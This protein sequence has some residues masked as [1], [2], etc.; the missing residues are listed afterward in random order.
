[1]GLKGDRVILETDI[2]YSCA[3]VASRGVTL[4]GKT[5]GSGVALGD[6]AGVADLV[7][8]PSGKKVLGI[9][10]NDVVNIDETRYHRNFHKDETKI[11]E[12]CTILKKGRVTTDKLAAGTT[13]GDGDTAY[14]T[15]NGELTPTVSTT[16]GI[17]ATPKVGQFRG[18][19][20]EAG[21]VCVEVN[22]PQI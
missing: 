15:T 17:A 21:F 14:L 3:S 4:V 20:D 2:T 22:L 13:P 11:N 12:R 7:A 8:S 5:A 9:L 1:M 10:L 6:S 16:G 19:K 18:G